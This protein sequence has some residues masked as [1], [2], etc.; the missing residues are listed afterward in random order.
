MERLKIVLLLAALVATAQ[1]LPGQERFAPSAGSANFIVVGDVRNC[2]YFPLSA[3]SRTTVR[4]AALNAGL[5][6]ESANVSV[7]RGNQESARW[8]QMIS[9]HSSDTGELVVSGDVIVVQSMQTIRESFQKNAVL[10]TELGG[11]VVTLADEGIAVGD[12]LQQTGNIPT[13]DH[14]LKI[15]SRFQGRPTI[16]Q[17]A[18][19]ETVEH[20]DVLTM[21]RVSRTT[22]KGFGR[23]APAFSEWQGS[24]TTNVSPSDSSGSAVFNNAIPAAPIPEA[25][26]TSPFLQIPGTF[27]APDH[28]PAEPIENE[29]DEFGSV[30]KSESTAQIPVQAVSQSNA[31]SAAS[32]FETAPVPPTEIQLLNETTPES[33]S[34]SM[35]FWNLLFV[36][37]LL[38]AGTFILVGSL[39]PDESNIPGPQFAAGQGGL[40]AAF[41]GVSFDQTSENDIKLPQIQTTNMNMENANDLSI[42]SSHLSQPQAQPVPY[43]TATLAIAQTHEWFGSDWRS[44]RKESSTSQLNISPAPIETEPETV[45]PEQLAL[46]AAVQPAIIERSSYLMETIVQ[47]SLSIHA[48]SDSSSESMIADKMKSVSP[49]MNTEMVASDSFADLEDLL[50]NRLPVDLCETQL[51]LRISLFGRPAGPRRLRIDAAHSKIPAPHMNRAAE[52][53]KKP[54]VVA[55][56]NMT[57]PNEQ[58]IN[59]P[60]SLDRALHYLQDR[61]DS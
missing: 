45:K 46:S 29:R 31:T 16:N 41:N 23:M 61:T 33:E 51:P 32:E 19:S 38:I 22:L 60:G 17:A 57:T 47:E 20:G 36:G 50:Q 37:G 10:R 59:A 12:V 21:S 43:E 53:S 2:N 15:A 8:T 44:V 49:M 3:D 58:S 48:K 30:V 39:R 18:L 11:I 13:P 6:S 1:T 28:E 27:Y 26:S 34:S 54:S 9:A 52:H 55:S 25:T 7:F 4:N 40:S 42:Q 24:T 14:Q 56:A 35:S 5:L